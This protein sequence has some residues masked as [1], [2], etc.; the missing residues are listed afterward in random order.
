[1]PSFRY[2][3]HFLRLIAALLL[4]GSLQGCMRWKLLAEPKALALKPYKTVR[5]TTGTTPRHLI[6][7][8]PTIVGDSIVWTTPERGSFP[9]D[10]VEWVEA[11]APDRMRAGFFI[12]VGVVAL[13]VAAVFN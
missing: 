12:F 8:N 6:V 13:T 3:T 5:L 7:H 9:I 11:R 4:V 2:P 1:M 10:E